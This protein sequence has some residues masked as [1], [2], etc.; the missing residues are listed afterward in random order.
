MNAQPNL[1]EPV[2]VGAWRLSNRSVMAPLTRNRAPGQVPTALMATYYAQ[3]AHPQDGAGLIISEA[4]PISPQAHGYADTPGLHSDAQVAAWRA[5]TD[6]VHARGGHIVTQLWHVGRISHVDLQPGGQAPVAPS[7]IAAKAKTYLIKPEGGG[8]FD[9]S[10]PRARGPGRVVHQAPTPLCRPLESMT[11]AAKSRRHFI[12]TPSTS[13]PGF[14]ST[15]GPSA[16][17]R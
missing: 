17:S 1:F 2:T 11:L 16:P 6:A 14:V 12:S 8:F 13:Q 10:P 5:V 9:V 3:R 4:T 15:M 7:A